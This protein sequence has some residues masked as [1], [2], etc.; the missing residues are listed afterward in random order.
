MSVKLYFM[1]GLPTETIEDVTG[2]TAL[3]QRIVDMYYSLPTRK[4]GKAV[5]VSISVST[6]VPKCFTPF[7]LSLIHIFP[8]NQQ[9]E[10]TNVSGFSQQ[11]RL[12]RPV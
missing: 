5:N 12:C 6:F 8:G 3:G 10:M 4:K 7:Q 11:H 2:I 9:G 1:L